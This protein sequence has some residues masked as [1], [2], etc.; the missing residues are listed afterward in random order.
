MIA[1]QMSEEKWNLCW[2][3][4]YLRGGASGSGDGPSAD[5][6]DW[7][8]AEALAR[9]MV[10]LLCRKNTGRGL[11]LDDRPNIEEVAAVMPS[12]RLHGRY[13]S[14]PVTNPGGR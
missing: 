7:R 3:G 4:M 8:P 5:R 14:R 1:F 11:D 10:A 13:Y 2:S 6:I 12:G 9:N